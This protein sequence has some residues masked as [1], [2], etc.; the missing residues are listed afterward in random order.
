MRTPSCFWVP[1]QGW[2]APGGGRPSTVTA[3]SFG[4]RCRGGTAHTQTSAHGRAGPFTGAR[5]RLRDRPHVMRTRPARPCEHSGRCGTGYAGYCFCYST[6]TVPTATL[7]LQCLLL[8][9]C[10][11]TYC[12]TTA[13]VPT[14]SA[15]ILLQHLLPHYCYSTY[16]YCYNTATVPT[17]TLLLQGKLSLCG[18]YIRP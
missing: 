11:S 6:A 4:V 10:D 12:Y 5:G 8:Q 14:V 13:T 16:C 9:Y 2:A 17:A 7:L 15:T 18:G 3:V 1:G